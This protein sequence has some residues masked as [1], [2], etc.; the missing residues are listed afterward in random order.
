M[1]ESER[2]MTLLFTWTLR[3]HCRLSTGLISVIGRPKE[4]RNKWG[5][6]QSAEQSKHIRHFWIKFVVLYGHCSRCPKTILIVM[7][8][9]THQR[10]PQGWLFHWGQTI[11][12]MII[13][14]KQL[15]CCNSYQNVTQGHKEST[16]C[17][18]IVLIDL[19]NARLP[20]TFNL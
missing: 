11:I 14:I 13:I 8:K 10:S 17:W 18:K 15:K 2:H 19:L 5:N 6:C 7:S 1:T 4:R 20:Q 12:M 3:N 9:I 16:C